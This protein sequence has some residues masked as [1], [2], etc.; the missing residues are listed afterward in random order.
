MYS[1][2][3]SPMQLQILCRQHTEC[4]PNC[5][6]FQ[7]FQLHIEHTPQHPHQTR[8]LPGSPHTPQSLCSMRTCLLH[9]PRSCSAQTHPS[10]QRMYQHRMQCILQPQLLSNTLTGILHTRLLQPAQTCLLHSPNRLPCLLQKSCQQH[11]LCMS[12]LQHWHEPQQH[13]DRM[14]MHPRMGH[15]QHCSTRMH[16]QHLPL[17]Q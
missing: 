12:P 11:R 5:L 3:L 6:N 10:M 8:A 2:H 14:L 1:P 15:C 9:M 4:I 17:L 13:I 16:H 7:T